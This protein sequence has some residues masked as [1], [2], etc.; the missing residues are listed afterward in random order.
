MKLDI[1]VHIHNHTDPGE[2]MR[3][4][5]I[6][7]ALM[8][9]KEQL[10]TVK[11]IVTA[12]RET[13]DVLAGQSTRI[14]SGVDNLQALVADLKQLLKAED[15]LSPEAQALLDEMT[16]TAGTAKAQLDVLQGNLERIGAD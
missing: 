6:E 9:I 5:R 4:T 14:G 12:M 3:L 1:H 15:K 7:R 13:T 16:A 10:N 11:G 8:T 2:D